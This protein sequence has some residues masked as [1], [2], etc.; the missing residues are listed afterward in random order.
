[1]AWADAARHGTEPYDPYA[2]PAGIDTEVNGDFAFVKFLDSNDKSNV[3][4]RDDVGNE[5]HVPLEKNGKFGPK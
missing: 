3:L 1:M 2:I 5:D 4:Y